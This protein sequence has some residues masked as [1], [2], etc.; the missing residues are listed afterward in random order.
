LIMLKK[1]IK[2]GLDS[3]KRRRISLIN[4]NRHRIIMYIERDREIFQD[5]LLN[6]RRDGLINSIMLTLNYQIFLIFI[7]I[8]L[9]CLWLKNVLNFSMK[10]TILILN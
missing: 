4:I 8:D 3:N 5:L 7:L 10:N 9:I 1:F 6:I 2:N